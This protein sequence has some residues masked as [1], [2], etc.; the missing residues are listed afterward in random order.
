MKKNNEFKVAMVNTF[1]FFNLKNKDSID[2]AESLVNYKVLSAQYDGL[3]KGLPF[4]AFKEAHPE[5]DF[6]TAER[7]LFV[8]VVEDSMIDNVLEVR[9]NALTVKAAIDALPYGLDAW[10]ALSDVDRFFVIIEAHKN[11]PAIVLDKYLF[12]D[13]KGVDL[14]GLT[15]AIKDAYTSG[16]SP[17]TRKVL[18]DKLRTMFFKV[19]GHGGELFTGISLTRSELGKADLMHFAA[20]F[21]GRAKRP[22]K[23]NKD[24]SETIGRYDYQLKADSW[25]SQSLALTTLLGVIIESRQND[26]CKV[27][28]G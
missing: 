12:R 24:G 13:E 15:E 5:V 3:V 2:K 7:D 25:K 1:R 4:D 20:T 21:G 11:A 27:V 28:R 26:I 6:W 22:V 23:K 16:M 14:T 8:G 17:A 18:V 9:E 10:N 19:C